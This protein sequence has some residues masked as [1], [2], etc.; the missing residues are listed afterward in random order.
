M[1]GMSEVAGV[2]EVTPAQVRAGLERGERVRLV[3]VRQPWEHA[4]RRIPGVLLLPTDQF[5]AHYESEL[6]PAD[7]IVCLCEHGVRSEAVARFLAAR[8]Y[9]NVSTMTGGMAAYDGPVETG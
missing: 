5:A 1:A 6:D 4:R 8:G 3:D 9:P 2:K 7:E